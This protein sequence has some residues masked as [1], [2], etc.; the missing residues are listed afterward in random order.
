MTPQDRRGTPPGYH[1][2]YPLEYPRG[3]PGGTPWVSPGGKNGGSLGVPLGY[4][5]WGPLRYPPWIGS[6]IALAPGVRSARG[7]GPWIQ[8]RRAVLVGVVEEVTQPIGVIVEAS[9]SLHAV[10]VRWSMVESPPPPPG[11]T[12]P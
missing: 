11:R 12:H 3:T 10:A 8:G 9:L 1:L 4:P 6:W 5:P 2:G 7:P